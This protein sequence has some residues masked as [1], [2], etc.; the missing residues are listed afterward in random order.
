M[1]R[2]FMLRFSVCGAVVL[3][4]GGVACDSVETTGGQL[5]TF[6]A[7]AAGPVDANG[8]Q[9][10]GP[11]GTGAPLTTVSGDVPPWQVTIETARLQIGAVYLIEGVYNGGSDNTM[12][13]VSDG[14]YNGQ[15]PGGITETATGEPGLN[16]LC[17]DP[18]EFS[19]FGNG[20]SGL[21][22]T[23]QIWLMGGQHTCMAGVDGGP[24]VCSPAIVDEYNQPTDNTAIVEVSGFA[25]PPGVAPCASKSKGAMNFQTT[26][27]ISEANRGLPAMPALPGDYPICLRRIIQLAPINVQLFQGGTLYVRADPRGWFGQVEFGANPPCTTQPTGPGTGDAGAGEGGMPDAGVHEAGMGGSSDSGSA[28]DTGCNAVCQGLQEVM[29]AT[30]DTPAIYA[31]PDTDQ[32]QIGNLF[33]GG[34]R[35]GT[36][37]SGA[38]VY[39]VDFTTSD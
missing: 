20:T 37:P 2:R 9:L 27:T 16:L 15:V 22:G 11:S 7:Y 31:I 4:A 19:V 1:A 39:S 14:V 24:Q 35:G 30:G 3:V 10:C 25:C 21:A 8:G 26:V 36:T 12:C 23:A 28:S 6:K 13:V 33:F 38:S 34:I 29:P 18:T 32:S 5:I 17:P